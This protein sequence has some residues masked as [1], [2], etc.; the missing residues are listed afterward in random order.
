MNNQFIILLNMGIELLKLFNG[1]KKTLKMF[2]IKHDIG[3]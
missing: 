1:Q 2:K 3:F